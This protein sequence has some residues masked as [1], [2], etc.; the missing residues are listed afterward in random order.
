MIYRGEKKVIF[1]FPKNGWF[2]I[3]HPIKMDDKRPKAC[4]VYCL[5]TE[6]PFPQ[7]QIACESR[8]RCLWV[9]KRGLRGCWFTIIRWETQ[10]LLPKN[11]MENH[12]GKETTYK[13]LVGALNPSE[14]YESQLG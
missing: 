2:I 5:A 7:I 1:K 3:D 9:G 8:H 13:I 12:H 14:K 4:V 11:Q 6:F 10:Q